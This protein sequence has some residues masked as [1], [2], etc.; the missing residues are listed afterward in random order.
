MVKVFRFIKYMVVIA[1]SI[2]LMLYIF[3][4]AVLQESYKLNPLRENEI[5]QREGK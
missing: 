2:V 5:I 3:I 4:G 1:L